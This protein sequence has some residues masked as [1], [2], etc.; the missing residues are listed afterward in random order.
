MRDW[1]QVVVLSELNQ[2]VPPAVCTKIDRNNCTN[3]VD[4]VALI[5]S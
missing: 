4:C 5:S 2:K 1:I 3:A